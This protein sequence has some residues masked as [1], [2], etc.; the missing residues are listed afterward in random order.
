MNNPAVLTSLYKVI[1]D[2]A[3]VTVAALVANISRQAFPYPLSIQHTLTT[4]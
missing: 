4:F 2:G 1:E 3:T